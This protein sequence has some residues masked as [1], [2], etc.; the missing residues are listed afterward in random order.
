ML[1]KT[2]AD[3]R[4]LDQAVEM[5]R[6]DNLAYPRV[7]EGLAALVV[8]PASLGRQDRYREGGYVRQLPQDPWGGAYQYAYPGEH[9][10]FD[11]YSYGA[12]GQPGGEGSNADIGNWQ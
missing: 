2:R 10:V 11:I 7:E 12:D 1:E 5:Y 3:V 4:L 8:P 9:G 6:L